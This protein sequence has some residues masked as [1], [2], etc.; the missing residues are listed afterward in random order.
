MKLL[1]DVPSGRSFRFHPLLN[2]GV[3]LSLGLGWFQ[4]RRGCLRGP[5]PDEVVWE[6]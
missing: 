3:F 2:S 6:V 4:D 1:R 5:F